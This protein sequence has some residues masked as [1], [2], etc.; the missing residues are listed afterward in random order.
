M[1]EFMPFA[2]GWFWWIAAG[3]L[4]FLE[5]L[6]PGT[7]FIF[8]AV[9]AGAVGL[10]DIAFDMGWRIEL[11]SF[12]GFA[13]VFVLAGRPFMG[14]RHVLDSDR[15]NLNRRMYDYVGKSYV[16]D[17]AIHNGRGRLKI[18]DTIWEVT[19]PDLPQGARIKVT[20]VDGLRLT[21]APD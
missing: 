5:L 10:L 18:E 19:G 6:S 12:A 4:M 9:A 11:L 1:G 15:P 21:V 16:L 20:A 2:G 17:E 13:L 7:Y 8:L 14:K 3:V